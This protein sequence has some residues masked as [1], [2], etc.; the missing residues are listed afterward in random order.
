MRSSSG[1]YFLGLEHIRGFAAFIVFTWH[2]IHIH[3]GHKLGAVIFP[4]NILTEGHTG[5]ALFMV[6]SGYLFAKIL[7]NK[8][9]IYSK[10][11]WNRL[12]RLLPLLFIVISIA[13]IIQIAEGKDFV[14]YLKLIL[15][16]IV[17]PSLPNGGW[18]ITVEFHFYLLLPFLLF[19]HRK[20]KHSLVLLLAMAIILRLI[21]YIILGQIQ[22]FSYWTIIGRIDQFLLGILAFK[23]SAYI[24]NQHIG[25][26]FVLL[27]FFVIYYYFEIQGG[28]Y[29]F[30]EYPS[31]SPIWIILPTIEGIAYGFII[32]WYDTSFKYS[33]SWVSGVIASAGRYS[34]SIYLFHF[35]FVFEMAK[36]IDNYLVD[37]SNIYIAIFF[38]LVCFLLM[39]PL[40]YLS[41][42]F[43]ESPFLKF[44]TNYFKSQQ[45]RAK[46]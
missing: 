21:L 31:H 6:L 5:V 20:W 4:F 19:L 24:K 32:S 44:R 30:P 1:K 37:L 13:G 41:F 9:I 17:I 38:S 29:G 14:Y 42:R 43:I 33:K 16:G 18:S 23:Y 10:F 2:F 26:F 22:D 27:L 12:I 45:V 34:Y 28:F 39:I 25:A 40:G 7:D 15:A 11:I 36:L 46:D 35:F 8:E 3:D